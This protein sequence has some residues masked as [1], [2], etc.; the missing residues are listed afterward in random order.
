MTE[1]IGSVSNSS[2]IIGCTSIH[3]SPNEAREFLEPNVFFAHVITV[4]VIFALFSVRA[5]E[6]KRTKTVLKFPSVHLDWCGLCRSMHY[7]H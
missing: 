5:H 7:V 6:E 1:Q 3:T 2:I 4:I